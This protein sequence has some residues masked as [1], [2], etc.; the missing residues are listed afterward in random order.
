MSC[1][2]CGGVSRFDRL[3]SHSFSTWD[4]KN[5][6]SF[7]F[8][9]IEAKVSFGRFSSVYD[10]GGSFDLGFAGSNEPIGKASIG[11]PSI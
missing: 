4:E 11:D 5:S 3:R 10:K 6:E 1:S 8:S 2:S 7:L 9:E